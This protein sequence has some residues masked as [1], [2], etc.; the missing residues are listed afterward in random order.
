MSDRNMARDYSE[1]SDE[2]RLFID[3]VLTGRNVLVDACI[4]SGKTTAIQSLCNKFDE[5]TMYSTGRP[6]HV[7]YLTYNNLLKVDAK[8][9]IQNANC[10]V[11][12]YHGFAYGMLCRAGINSR[13]IGISDSIQLFN[14]NWRRVYPHCRNFDVMILDEYQ[15]IDQEI[16]EM[17]WRVAAANPAMQ[18]IAV[19]DMCQKIYDKTC[20]NVPEF[21]SEFLG[22][23]ADKLEFTKC[24]RLQAEHAANLGHV[25]GKKIIG[26]NESCD[27]E[28]M[29]F[30]EAF[31][32]LSGVKPGDMLCLGANK[33]PRVK[34]QNQL[35]KQYPE[36]FNKNTLWSNISEGDGR[37]RSFDSDCAIFTTYDGCKGMERPVCVLFDWDLAYWDL[38]LSKSGVKYEIL[39]NIFLVAASRGKDKIIFVKSEEKK[40][41]YD[42]G[43]TRKKPSKKSTFLT[44]DVLAEPQAGTENFEDV[45]ISDMFDFKYIEHIEAAYK[46][47]NIKELQ[48]DLTSIDIQNF[49]GFIDL[50]PCIG[51]YQEVFYFKNSNIDAYIDEYFATH[52]RVSPP[53]S[54][55][56]RQWTIEQKILYLSMLQLNQ[57][58]YF[59]QV[60]IPFVSQEQASA[61]RERLNSELPEDAITQQ[62]CQVVFSDED[63]GTLF[64][65]VGMCDVIHDNKLWELK[66]TSALQHTHFLQTAMYMLGHNMET[67]RLWNV[68]TNQM[69]EIKIP[70]PDRFLDAVIV[71]VTKGRY[72]KYY[73]Q[74]FSGS[75]IGQVGA[76]DYHARV[77][78]FC[79]ENVTVCERLDD[80]IASG[81][82]F[83]ARQVEEY[84]ESKGVKLSVPGDLY[85]KYRKILLAAAKKA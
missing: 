69:Y 30:D 55:D 71:A 57:A 78:K 24:F 43:F 40:P 63:H 32:Y 72:K 9:K 37:P 76:F 6:P 74:V 20:L 34:M 23:G 28:Y 81:E 49:D 58:R 13:Q 46:L 73:G 85:L 44:W 48:R 60:E 38:R 80:L 52:P 39:R 59:H 33:G 25:W 75:E 54:G 7:L 64:S 56:W 14:Q 15:D 19:G 77:L 82:R 61:I 83:N 62:R 1:L 36:I 66:F 2:Q 70:K 17:L 68:K 4:G 41:K 12:N 50:S 45:G 29:S 3:S 84:F 47:L 31:D 11:T 65:A 10:Q 42:W 18:R 51:V 16:S 21:M 8:N 53:K 26:V 22:D 67:G 27:I 5:L 79:Q 35:E